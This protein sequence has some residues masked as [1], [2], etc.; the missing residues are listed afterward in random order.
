MKKIEWSILRNALIILSFSVIIG[1]GFVLTSYHNYIDTE[2]EKIGKDTDFTKIKKEYQDIQEALQMV[3]ADSVRQF[4]K[5][6]K[7]GFFID[8]SNNHLIVDRQ[9]SLFKNINKLLSELKLANKLFSGEIKINLK[10]ATSFEHIGI[11]IKDKFKVYQMQMNIIFNVL[12]EGDLL[13]LITKIDTYHHE[14]T[15][16]LNF[17]YCD[18]KRNKNK[19]ELTNASK[20]Y[21]EVKCTFL[22][23]ISQIE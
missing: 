3:D 6:K 1:T 22:H 9:N 11:D 23:Y 8:K 20:P 12:H 18:I 19:I 4:K 2:Q 5:L 16:L 17:K 21:F 7:K 10:K 13:E 14:A 15:G